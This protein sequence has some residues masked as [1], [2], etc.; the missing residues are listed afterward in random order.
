MYNF[1]FSL[2]LQSFFNEKL[3]VQAT[4]A[5][6]RLKS[7]RMGRLKRESH[8][9]HGSFDVSLTSRIDGM[10]AV[11]SV[12][13]TVNRRSKR[14]L[15]VHHVCH[16]GLDSEWSSRF[17][18]CNTARIDMKFGMDACLKVLKLP[19]NFWHDHSSGSG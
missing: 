5:F 15:N 19:V 9:S 8:S 6:P 3:K 14:S 4:G 7:E 11:A 17:S 16:F 12:L 13:P 10:L 2:D 1:T 18:E